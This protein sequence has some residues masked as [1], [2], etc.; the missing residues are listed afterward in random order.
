MPWHGAQPIYTH[1]LVFGKGRDMQQEEF[2]RRKK[3]PKRIFRK[4]A[5]SVG[6]DF[7]SLNVHEKQQIVERLFSTTR[8][9]LVCFPPPPAAT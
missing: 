1:T 8:Y 3:I 6:T 5:F 7:I 4:E 9:T 2:Q